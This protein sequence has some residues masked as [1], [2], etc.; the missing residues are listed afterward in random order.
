M[1]D[2][3][4]QNSMAPE[5][6]AVHLR[7]E[8]WASWGRQELSSLGL[9]TETYLS[10][11]IEY[12]IDGAQQGGKIPTMPDHVAEVDSA[13]AHLPQTI[14]QVI[15]TYYLRWEPKA[16]MARRCR[17]SQGTFDGHLSRGRW[18]LVGALSKKPF[19]TKS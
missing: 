11:W 15:K 8:A 7:L 19:A 9:P 16:V 4:A 18:Y 2:R 13:V 10:R 12:G 5:I 17:M 3:R 1:S 14:G 6:R